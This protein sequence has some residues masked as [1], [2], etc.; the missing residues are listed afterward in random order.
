MVARVGIQLPELKPPESTMNKPL[1]T[2]ENWAV[3]QRAV[4]L[5]YEELQPGRHL[6]GKVV[7][8]ETLPNA[9]FIYTSPIVSVDVG[10]GRVET[11][12]TVYKL[13]QPSD[14]YRIWEHTRKVEAA[15]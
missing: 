5:S 6:M 2:I 15:A 13:G 9:D 3:V 14:A 11:R 4:A 8:H 12:N 7:G 1:V 10:E